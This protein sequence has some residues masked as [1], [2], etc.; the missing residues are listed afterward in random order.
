[1]KFSLS[2]SNSASKITS[3]SRARI[4]Y[5]FLFLRQ[6]HFLIKSFKEITLIYDFLCFFHVEAKENA[7]LF[8][9]LLRAEC[10]L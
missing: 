1:M 7:F 3:D 2:F 9:G 4:F 5:F 10:A 8:D 6:S